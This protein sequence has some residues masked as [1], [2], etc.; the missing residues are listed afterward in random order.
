MDLTMNNC[1]GKNIYRGTHTLVKGANVIRLKNIVTTNSPDSSTKS[2]DYEILV[3]QTGYDSSYSY[4]A[5]IDN[6]I[7]NKKNYSCTSDYDFREHFDRIRN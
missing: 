2:I 6:C 4:R 7:F 1:E 3:N 5:W